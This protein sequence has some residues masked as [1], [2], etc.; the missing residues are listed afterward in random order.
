MSA[1]QQGSGSATWTRRDLVI[2]ALGLA[3][4]VSRASA[5]AGAGQ[6]PRPSRFQVACMTYVYRDFPLQRALEGIAKSGYRHVAW[7]TEHQKSPGRRAPVLAIDAPDS[8]ARRLGARCRDLGLET[9]I[10]G[11]QAAAR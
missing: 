9:V 7:G 11:L 10:G 4:A 3:A 2:G 6:D 1:N 8:D 5:E